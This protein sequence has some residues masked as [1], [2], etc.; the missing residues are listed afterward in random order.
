MD[1]ESFIQD[2]WK[3]RTAVQLQ[4][5]E[6]EWKNLHNEKRRADYRNI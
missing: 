1:D 4:T 3:M 5:S 6:L 2:Y